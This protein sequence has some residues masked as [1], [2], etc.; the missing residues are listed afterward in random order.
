MIRKGGGEEER[1]EGRR[2]KKRRLDE[3]LN[4]TDG[5]NINRQA[6]ISAGG[7]KTRWIENGRRRGKG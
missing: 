2:R 5:D 1:K 7:Q 4:A 3:R 6:K